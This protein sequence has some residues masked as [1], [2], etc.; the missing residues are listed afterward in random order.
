[1]DNSPIPGATYRLQFNSHFTFRDARHLAGYLDDLGITHIYASPLLQSRRGS[2]HGYDVTDPAHL[3]SELGSEDDFEALSAELRRRKMGLLLDIVPNHMAADIENPWW[4]DVLENGP[5]SAYASHFDIDW[6]PPLGDLENKVLLPILG[7]S[8]GRTLERRALRLI[9]N[10]GRF[11][12]RYRG[13]LLPVAP[14][15]YR[16]I[17]EYRLGDLERA[18]GSEAAD[19]REFNG[20]L[21][22]LAALSERVALRSEA[23][24][25]RRLRMEEVKERLSRLYNGNVEVRNFLDENVRLFNGERGKPQ[26]FLPLD[27]LLR[28]Q[29][30]ML[31][32]WRNANEEINYRRFFAVSELVGVRVEDPLVFDATHAAILRLIEKGKVE[33]LRVDH[34]DGLWDPLGYLRRLRE[35]LH[36]LKSRAESK[37]F[38]IVVEKILSGDEVLPDDWPVNG[39]TGYDLLN[40]VNRLFVD[41]G[42][43]KRIDHAYRKFLGASPAYEDIVY[44]KKKQVMETLLAVEARAL[45]HQLAMI[46]E[47]DRYARDLP[48]DEI[49]KALIETTACLSV[50]RTAMRNFNVTPR[51]RRALRQALAI[52]RRRNPHLDPACF[53]FLGDV[54]LLRDGKYLYPEQREARLAFVMR[55]QQFTGPVTAKGIEDSALYVYNRLISLNEVGGDPR[56]TAIAVTA[57]H[58]FIQRRRRQ[59]PF[60]MNATTTHDTKRAEDVRARI[61]VLSEIP[62]EWGKRLIQWRRWNEPHKSRVRGQLVPYPNEE[63]FLY[64]TLV[65]AWPLGENEIPSFTKRLKKYVIKATREANVHTRWTIPNVQH[66]RAL[67]RFAEAILKPDG[68]NPFLKDFL[69]FQERVAY[70]GMLNGLSQVLLKMTCPG[71]PDFYQGSEL[72]DLRLVD[73][74]NRRPV[75]FKIRLRLLE[76]IK[77][78]RQQ[79]SLNLARDLTEHWKDG[80]IK[81]YLIA[82]TLSFRKTHQDVFRDGDDISLKALGK[83]E[84][85]VCAFARR[86]N[87][88]WV[89][90]VVPRFMAS[91]RT[92]SEFWQSTRLILPG[93]APQH[94]VNI[95]TEESVSAAQVGR[96][97]VLFLR[98]LFENFPVALLTGG[99]DHRLD[100]IR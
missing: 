61:N 39:T 52:A 83:R 37:D 5:G 33:G 76:K 6:H 26:S 58:R 66:E 50:Y 38:Y 20:I 22:V 25:G 48:Q 68:R 84:R 88:M 81:L 23:M 31:V 91:S 53:D 96:K 95:L 73:P 70:G 78:R 82:R 45:G 97:P 89:L 17:L 60:S 46:A 11:F 71:V 92:T 4:A 64:Q 44:E 18:L 90:A 63:V 86:S 77:E 79:G 30:Y 54:L 51:E 80:R 34:I 56:Y 1:M 62:E 65:G 59:W 28:E 16:C 69:P 41:E 40:V 67:I 10:E 21:A 35:S 57:F 2:E 9:L 74:D 13:T 85:N 36:S 99:R 29:A 12:I 93:K 14:K 7:D 55:W 94:W 75:D 100:E 32:F 87:K 47:Q 15:S 19:F 27:H 72:W 42:G 43:M 98:G 24:G 8:Y 49:V 3:D